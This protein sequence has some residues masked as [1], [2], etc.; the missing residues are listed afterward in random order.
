MLT[1]YVQRWSDRRGRYRPAGEPIQTRAYDIE[2]IPDD[3]SARAFIVQHHYA[4]S[5]PPTRYRIGLYDRDGLAGVAIFSVPVNDA[6]L[7]ELPG[8]GLERIELGRFVLL[9]RVPANGESWFLARC[10]ELLRAEGLTGVLSNSDPEPRTAA[11]G[12]LIFCGHVGTIY[13]ATNAVYLG[14]GTARTHHLLPD[15][16]VF[17]PRALQKLRAGESG[18]RYAAEL[19]TAHGA[20]PLTDFGDRLVWLRDWLPRVCRPL[21]HPGNHRYG[22]ALNKRD[23]ARLPASLAYPKVAVPQ[24]ALDLL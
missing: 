18:W 22:W 15:G 10:F 13:Q 5:L 11:D 20:P 16:T 8:H 2:K 19:L 24:L 21:R 14:R 7:R 1:D 9:D 17:S 6:S 4:P 3:A 12:R 23:R